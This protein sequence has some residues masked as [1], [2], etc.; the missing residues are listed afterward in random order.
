MMADAALPIVIAAV[1]GLC[2]LAAKRD[3]GLPHLV[4]LCAFTLVVVGATALINLQAAPIAALCFACLLIAETD[5][6]HALIPDML[7]LAIALLCLTLP[8]G[9]A[10]ALQVSGAVLLGGVFLII[11]QTCSAW[12]GI[13]ALGWGDVKLAA[14]MGAVLGPTYGFTAVAIAG[15]ATI[16]V[17]LLARERALSAAPGAPFGVGLAAALAAV[18][19][20]RTA[21]P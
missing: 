5:R 3:L 2:A 12:R 17:A 9:D 4:T 14:A 20:V 11:R 8:F 7:T 1:A 15:A 13:E 19:L 16:P 18:A 21:L 6:R 10:L